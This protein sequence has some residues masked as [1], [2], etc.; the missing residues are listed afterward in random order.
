MPIV[1]TGGFARRARAIM[2]SLVIGELSTGTQLILKVDPFLPYLL[3]EFAAG[4]Y[5]QSEVLCT[6]WIEI[7]DLLL[8]F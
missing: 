1:T 2:P 7:W 8:E 3:L 4:I 5:F 6:L